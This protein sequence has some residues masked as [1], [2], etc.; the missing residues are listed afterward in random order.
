MSGGVGNKNSA[1]FSSKSIIC[2]DS[3]HAGA[4]LLTDDAH[5]VGICR[6]LVVVWQFKAY[7]VCQAEQQQFYSVKQ[8]CRHRGFPTGQVGVNVLKGG[9]ILRVVWSC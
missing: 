4:V 1:R 7:W 5:S 8:S 3:Q 2:S 9:I 6:M